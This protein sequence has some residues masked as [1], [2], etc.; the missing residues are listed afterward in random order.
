ML[1]LD[2]DGVVGIGKLEHQR[3]GRLLTNCSA[4]PVPGRALDGNY[5]TDM[6]RRLHSW[7]RRTRCQAHYRDRALRRAATSGPPMAI[8]CIHADCD[9]EL[10]FQAIVPK[11]E[12]CGAKSAIGEL[13]SSGI[14]VRRF[15]PTRSNR[16]ITRPAATGCSPSP[17][18]STSRSGT[19]RY[20][21]S[22]RA[23]S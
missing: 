19:A 14:M 10:R 7:S 9:S 18:R 22:V 16:G 15:E 20:A 17:A 1:P 2:P 5:L 3:E 23:T 6:V 21:G 8:I 12:L 13:I 11:H 4:Q